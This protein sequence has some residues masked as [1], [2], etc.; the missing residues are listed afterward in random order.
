MNKAFL[1]SLFVVLFS[2]CTKDGSNE[3]VVPVEYADVPNWQTVDML[4][5]MP[6][7]LYDTAHAYTVGT[8]SYI[9]YKDVKYRLKAQKGL[10]DYV[11]SDEASTFYVTVFDGADRVVTECFVESGKY[12][13]NGSP[14]YQSQTFKPNHVAPF[15]SSRTTHY[16]SR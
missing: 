11:V 15:N 4:A 14:V 10:R 3:P 2:S 8:K 12:F 1:L 5:D 16:Y 13:R 9:L 6:A 7:G